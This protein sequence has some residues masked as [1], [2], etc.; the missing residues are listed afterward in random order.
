LPKDAEFLNDVKIVEAGGNSQHLFALDQNGS[1]Y[2]WE[3]E[4]SVKFRLSKAY[5]EDQFRNFFISR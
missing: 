5:K 1:C 4:N 2:V 3:T